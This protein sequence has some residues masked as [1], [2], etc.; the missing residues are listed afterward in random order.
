MAAWRAATVALGMVLLAACGPVGGTLSPREFRDAYA[1]VIAR[2][3]PNVTVAPLGDDMVEVRHKDG[4]VARARIDNAYAAYRANPAALDE[5]LQR[6]AGIVASSMAADD[7]IVAKDLVVLVRPSTYVPSGSDPDGKPQEPPLTRPLAEGLLQ[8]V[9]VD[10][11]DSFMVPPADALREELKMDHAAIWARALANTEAKVKGP[12]PSAQTVVVSTGEGLAV[13]LMAQEAY[14]DAPAMQAGGAPVVSPVGRDELVIVH[15]GAP[16]VVDA[17]KR[18]AGQ[19]QRED[20][21]SNHVFVRRGGK[22]VKLD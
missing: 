8:F 2:D 3:V 10:R 18:S 1:K 11:A 17:L 14:W 7:S 21:V 20:L 22:W 6:Y 4:G 9:A 16:E 19:D 12:A 13:S 5:I 15:Q